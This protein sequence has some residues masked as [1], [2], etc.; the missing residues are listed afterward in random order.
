M[1]E[2]GIQEEDSGR[3]NESSIVHHQDSEEVPKG[4]N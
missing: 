3:K 1:N 4:N 2:I